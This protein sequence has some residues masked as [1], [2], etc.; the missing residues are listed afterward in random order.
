MKHHSEIRM[1]PA[2]K[3]PTS[4]THCLCV[5]RIQKADSTLRS[6]RA[7]PHPSANRALRRLTSEV[8]RDPVHKT[9]YGRRRILSSLN[10]HFGVPGHIGNIPFSKCSPVPQQRSTMAAAHGCICD[11]PSAERSLAHSMERYTLTLNLYTAFAR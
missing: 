2:C 6:S 9:R 8:R 11:F 4:R 5:Q 10:I 3:A 1:R 7:V